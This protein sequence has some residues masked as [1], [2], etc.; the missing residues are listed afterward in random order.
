MKRTDE[1]VRRSYTEPEDFKSVD[2]FLIELLD[3][4]TCFAP[5]LLVGFLA[6][7]GRG[8][9]GCAFMNSILLVTGRFKVL[10]RSTI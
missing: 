9:D 3:A 10:L 6:D 4:F 5:L 2:D 8:A 7:K 1:S